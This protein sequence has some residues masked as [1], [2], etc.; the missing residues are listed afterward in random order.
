MSQFGFAV[1]IDRISKMLAIAC[2]G[3]IIVALF[4]ARNTPAAGQESSIYTA[5]PPIVWGFLIFSIISGL[6]IVV[7]QIYLGKHEKDRIWL[8]GLLLIL[9]SYTAV[10]SLHIVRGYLLWGR[11]DVIRHLRTTW[12]IISTG[13]FQGGNYYP[14]SHIFTAQLSHILGVDALVLFGYIPVLFAVLYIAFMYLLAR[15]VLP[16][17]G[18]V[19]LATIA[20]AVIVHHWYISFGPSKLSIMML[21][22]AFYLGIRILSDSNLQYRMQFAILFI[23]LIFLYPLFHMQ[24]AIAIF[25][26]L[27]TL[28]IPTKIYRRLRRNSAAA[29]TSYPKWRSSSATIL[30]V[31]WFT[32]VSSF[33]I[34]ATF[35]RNVRDMLRGGGVT[36][37]EHLG[38]E[39]SKVMGYGYGVSNYLDGFVRVYGNMLL[40]I[41][42]ALVAFP[43][44][45]RKLSA[46]GD[47]NNLYSLYGPLAA[48][49]LGT[50][51]L[52]LGQELFGPSRAFPYMVMTATIFVGFIL[53]EMIVKAQSSLRGRGFA[54]L[55]L[56]AVVLILGL[57]FV[58][59]SYKA[60]SSPYIYTFSQQVAENEI[61][62]V[63]FLFHHRDTNT[64]TVDYYAVGMRNLHLLLG[65]EEAR[66][67]KNIWQE[68]GGTIP[69]HFGYDSGSLLGAAYYENKYMVI[70][71]SFRQLYVNVF[72][73][74]AE[75]RFLPSDFEKLEDDFSLD[76]V[77]TNGELDVWEVHGIAT[78]NSIP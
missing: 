46:R 24:P 65:E 36:P 66:Y 12:E 40:F 61:R 54:K 72:P 10:L 63:D 71:Y 15:S 39:M 69:L 62:G 30:I 16:S 21:P 45:S 77:Y 27:V 32:W 74:L 70:N 1:N 64:R 3:L 57:T 73:R 53:H 51:V 31:W 75:H 48:F 23:I 35:I 68:P 9:L 20:S 56:V 47:L 2:L 42:I 37:L 33:G 43:I 11:G 78:P 44:I 41:I 52:Y 14:I 67:G 26:F 13:H 8:V 58:A 18:Q 59:G 76:K 25:I 22:L 60:Y 7:Y 28:W 5:T 19:I 38:Q 6:S 34:Y 4:V 49:A 50:I 29:T 55:T 17:K